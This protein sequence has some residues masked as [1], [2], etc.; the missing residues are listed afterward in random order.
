MCL[1]ASK[2][3]SGHAVCMLL[4]VPH[5]FPRKQR[6]CI[7]PMLS[8]C[9]DTQ[10]LAG[11][12]DIEVALTVQLP[13]RNLQSSFGGPNTLRST[14]GRIYRCYIV[15]NSEPSQHIIHRPIYL[16]DGLLLRINVAIFPL[17]R[18]HD[19][20]TMPGSPN[21]DLTDNFSPLID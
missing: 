10:V 16:M 15:P 14:Q 6:L 21:S 17:A 20:G 1:A 19:I 9:W 7:C 5:S 2:P 4:Q 8:A 12:F 18:M 11:V 3:C 13:G